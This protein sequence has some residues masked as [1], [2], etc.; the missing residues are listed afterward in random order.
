[1]NLRFLCC[2]VQEMPQVEFLACDITNKNAVIEALRGADIVYHLAALVSPLHLFFVLTRPLIFIA[3]SSFFSFFTLPLYSSIHPS[4]ILVSVSIFLLRCSLLLFFPSIHLPIHPSNSQSVSLG[5]SF[6]RCIDPSNIPPNIILSCPLP[7]FSSF[8]F[9]M[10]QVGPFHPKPMYEKVNYEGTLNIVAGCRENGIGRLVMMSSPSTRFQGG[11][12]WNL[13]ESDLDYPKSYL[14]EYARTKAMGEQAVFEQCD[15]DLHA[16]AV[17]PHQVYGDT[18]RLFLPNLLEAAQTGRLRIFGSGENVVSFT[19]VRNISHA[20]ILAGNHLGEKGSETVGSA[21]GQFF[22]ITDGGGK[23]F[24]DSIDHAVLELGLPSLWSKYHLP[25]WLL[26]SLAYLSDA[27][28]ATLNGG[29]KLKLN[30]FTVRMMLIHRFFDIQKARD[31]IGYRP[32]VSFE[33]GWRSAIK[34]AVQTVNDPEWK[35]SKNT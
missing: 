3:L 8:P 14:A 32:I 4:T 20:C 31:L 27:F 19:H 16:C 28:S 30:S 6:G 33:E 24:W 34:H 26:W 10:I 17:A 5:H 29:R 11:D 15:A 22:F 2:A 25:R 1:M 13:S 12:I 23:N 18:D 7:L 35:A 21:D 9:P